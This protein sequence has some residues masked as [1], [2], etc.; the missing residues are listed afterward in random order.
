MH[1]VIFIYLSLSIVGRT[2]SL[3]K[4]INAS[5]PTG[6]N[7]RV[8]HFSR[9]SRVLQEF[10]HEYKCLSLIVLNNKDF[11]PKQRESISA[12]TSMGLNK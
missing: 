5:I 10:S 9:F 11:W 12:K 7:I 1:L 8:F 2:L 3:L 6:L 4:G